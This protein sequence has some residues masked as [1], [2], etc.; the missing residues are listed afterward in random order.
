[1]EHADPIAPVSFPERISERREGTTPAAWKEVAASLLLHLFVG[2][3]AIGALSGPAEIPPPVID[4]TLADP[5]GEGPPTSTGSEEARVRRTDAP[6]AAIRSDGPSALAPPAPA[7]SF[8]AATEPANLTGTA[9]ALSDAPIPADRPAAPL[10][11]SFPVDAASG[12]PPGAA[13]PARAATG[14]G[15]GKE[16]AWSR[17]G[18]PGPGAKVGDFS[19]I[20]DAI[21]RGIAYPATARKMGWEGKVVVAFRLL[22]DGS[23][24]DVR[25]V[26]GSGHAALDRGAVAAVRNASP[27]PRPPVEAE[28]ITPVVYRLAPAP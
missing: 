20:R 16:T 27:F 6:V 5:S 12:S 13:A 26:R 24:R 9:P 4:L 14:E 23:V 2:A 21:Q 28:I 15:G 17:P 10:S 22:S 18:T 11:P 3:V 1:M 19:R 25:V 8:P 7:A